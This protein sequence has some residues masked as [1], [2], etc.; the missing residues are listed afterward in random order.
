MAEV[1]SQKEMLI[2]DKYAIAKIQYEAALLQYAND[3]K[4][5]SMK[6]EIINIME[7]SV[8]GIMPSLEV[9]KKVSQSLI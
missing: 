7:N 2:L 9:G 6:N 5:K 4:L 1:Y 3:E 8:R